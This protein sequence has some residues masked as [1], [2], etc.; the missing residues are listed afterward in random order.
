MQDKNLWFL[1]KSELQVHN[2][3][4]SQNKNIKKVTATF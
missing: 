4:Q 2:L 1:E 3:F